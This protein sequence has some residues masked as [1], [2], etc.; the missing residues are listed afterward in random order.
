MVI[1]RILSIN[2]VLI[3]MLLVC[4]LAAGSFAGVNILRLCCFLCIN[5]TAIILPGYL[6]LECSSFH[7]KNST[8]QLFVGYGVGYVMMALIYAILVFYNLHHLSP[9]IIYAISVVSLLALLNKKLRNDFLSTLLDKNDDNRFL[10][11]LMALLFLFCFMV[12]QF[13]HRFVGETGYLDMHFD[14]TYWF[15]NC[16]AA[17]KGYPFPELSIYGVTLSWHMFSCFN[18]ALF[19]FSTGIE[20]YDFCFSLSYVWHVFMM[21]GGAYALS[22]KILINRKYIFT[23]LVLILLCSSA[24]PYTI[25]YYLDHLW[26]CSMG[27]SD[28][29]AVSMIAM[30]LLL[31]CLNKQ[32][33][34]WQYVPLTIMMIVAATGYKSANGVIL[35]V[36]VACLLGYLC[37]KNRKM[38]VSSLLF[39][40]ITVILFVVLCKTFIIADGALT[41]ST[42]HHRLAL[43]FMTV[44]RPDINT[45][46]VSSLENVG[47]RPLITVIFLAI[48]YLLCVH[49]V[50][51]L[52][53]VTMGALIFRKKEVWRLDYDKLSVCIPFLAMSVA[54]ILV[55]L[56]FNHPGF[57]QC[58][59]LFSGIPFEVLFSFV[60]IEQYFAHSYQKH[61][62]WLYSIIFISFVATIVC[63]K[64]VYT[65]DGKYFPDPRRI[66]HEGTSLTVEEIK[67]LRWARANLPQDAVLLTNKVLAPVRGERSFI[68]STYMERQVYIEGYISANLPNDHIV[69]D[70]LS[71]TKHYF[72]GDVSARDELR[73]DGVT[74]VVIYKSLSNMECKGDKLL[75][76]NEEIEI[77][78]L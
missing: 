18:I 17:T 34:N 49:P 19:H 37:I 33:I 4:L 51:P 26:G 20:I 69:A 27:T 71:L 64:E 60:I 25:V 2:G 66:S 53:A 28:A 78:T 36:G 5:L 74:H 43:D 35:L 50:M 77:W 12:F 48:P 57:A 21:V 76:K 75:Y 24:E 8:T 46:I 9:Y 32:Q 47:V 7:F 23:T 40:L 52:F 56:S 16:I 73:R 39:L 44:L 41:S 6:L 72:D 13:P 59:F 63:A 54:G 31:E 30:L 65:L 42:S 67:G 55:F 70:R 11:A 45:D 14:N 62:F 68:T 15:K 22:K 10:L 38:L 3:A 29:I 58:Y 1:K 61:R